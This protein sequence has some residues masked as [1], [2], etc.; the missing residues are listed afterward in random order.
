MPI[1]NFAFLCCFVYILFS[2]FG[3]GIAFV[4]L[5][6]ALLCLYLSY[7]F[8]T[9]AVNIKKKCKTGKDLYQQQMPSTTFH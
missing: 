1:C 4:G 3:Y 8:F 6:P 5:I 7:T 9:N 2:E